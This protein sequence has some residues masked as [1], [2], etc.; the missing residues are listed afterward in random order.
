MSKIPPGLLYLTIYNPSLRPTSLTSPDD[1]DAEEQAQILFY[2]ARERA[3]SRDRMLRQ[4]GLAKALVNFSDMFNAEMSCESVHSQTRR[5]I[6]IE[7][8]PDYWIHACIELA[9]TPRSVPSKRKGKEKGKSKNDGSPALEQV[10][11]CHDSSVHDVSIRSHIMRGYEDFKLIHGS[12]TSI[13][14]NI[15][16]QALELQ[17]ERFFTIWA[18]K[19]DI[20]QHTSFA[21]DLGTPLHP[22]APSLV[23]L[24]DDLANALPDDTFVFALEPPYVVPSTVLTSHSL[25]SSSLVRH[26]ISRIP[27]PVAPQF[28]AL[29]DLPPEQS[30]TKEVVPVPASVT[31]PG[32]DPSTV[33][34]VTQKS[35]ESAAMSS[36]VAMANVTRAMD[37]R[38]LK[39]GWLSFGKGGG[40]RPTDM[41]DSPA[42]RQSRETAVAEESGADDYGKWKAD[43]EHLDVPGQ[44]TPVDVDRESLQEALSIPHLSPNLS[45]TSIPGSPADEEG[46]PEGDAPQSQ[47]EVEEPDLTTL[48]D[49]SNVRGDLVEFPPHPVPQGPVELDLPESSTP[50]MA[51]EFPPACPLPSLQPATIHL[52]DSSDPLATCRRR[53]WQTTSNGLTVAFITDYERHEPS[54]LVPQTMTMVD[55]LRKE[56]GIQQSKAASEKPMPSATNILQPQSTHVL[57]VNGYTVSSSRPVPNNPEQ[58]YHAKQVFQSDND[59]S[60]VFSRGQNPQHW[61]VAKR[62]LE[63]TDQPDQAQ[64]YM[65]IARKENTLTDVDNEVAAIVREFAEQDDGWS[66]LTKS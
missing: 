12:F 44:R 9:K 47:T 18:W 42:E 56:L 2:T 35:V 59:V 50:D 6:T 28:A 23:P 64:V 49:Q 5:M 55:S 65:E 57:A 54:D 7:P 24:V 43:T 25:L 58:L 16:Q 37:P 63:I 30:G 19:W 29:S 15:G 1:E 11:E 39:W 48:D 13:L 14:S 41:P 21:A 53:I 62:R 20:E 45:S 46:K 38:Q 52:A 32:L 61:H 4:V 36:F 66:L 31:S 27:P 8:E 17:L 33:A 3:V 60:E 40:A 22:L 51:L 26:V 10:Y 34:Q